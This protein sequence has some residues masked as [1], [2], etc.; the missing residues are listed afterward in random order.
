MLLNRERATDYMRRHNLDAL[1]ATGAIDVNYLSDY[2]CWLHLPVKEYFFA[3]GA[4]SNLNE[5]YALLPIEGEPALVVTPSFA[6]TA[7]DS[8]VRDV[9]AGDPGF[10]PAAPHGTVP[11]QLARVLDLVAHPRS[12]ATPLDALL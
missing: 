10:D 4:S 11:A 7:A 6:V 9:R 5:I 8:S 2:R 12:L 1:I 3:P